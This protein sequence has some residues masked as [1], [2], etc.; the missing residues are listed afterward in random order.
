MWSLSKFKALLLWWRRCANQGSNQEATLYASDQDC[1]RIFVE[2]A[3]GLFLLSFLLTGESSLAEG[4][5]VRAFEDS[6]EG[7]P[8]F[9]DWMRSWTRRT[10]I[11]RAIRESRPRAIQNRSL[12]PMSD[13][14]SIN[15]AA[16]PAEI[17]NIVRLPLFERFVFV[18][19][20]LERYSPQECSLLLDCTRS[21]VIAARAWALQQIASLSALSRRA[22][23]IDWDEQSIR[24]GV[25]AVSPLKDPAA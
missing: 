3:N 10:I 25:L 17:A 14:G 2:E 12:S 18:M 4:C 22:L 21:N 15:I 24:V 8:V 19:S 6:L 5:F 1:C 20:V 23:T 13:G 11:R 9:K 16:Q 7:N